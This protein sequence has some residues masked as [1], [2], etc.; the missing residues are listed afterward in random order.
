M[1]VALLTLGLEM[2]DSFM[3]LHALGICYRDSNYGNFFFHPT[4]GEIRIAD[5]DNVDVNMRPGSILGTPGFMA[6]EVGRREAL[7]NSMSDRFSMAVS[8]FNLLMMGHPLKGKRESE[9]PFDE[10]DRD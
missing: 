9:L 10:Q 5:T 7:P 3:K 1:A 4:T 2:P 8:L 6:L